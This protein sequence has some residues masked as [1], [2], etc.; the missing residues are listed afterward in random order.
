MA[1][2]PGVDAASLLEHGDWSAVP[3]TLPV[4]ALAF[5]YHNIVPVLVN[6][7]EA[8]V[9][10]VRTA[11]CAGVAIPWIMFVSW[12]AAILGSLGNLQGA[13]AAQAP[14]AELS[15]ATPAGSRDLQQ[16]GAGQQQQVPA[17]TVAADSSIS[18]VSQERVVLDQRSSSS[19]SSQSADP[20]DALAA[21][22]ATVGPLIQGFSFLA[23]ATSYIGFILGLT[24]F[25]S[26]A[27][28]LPNRQAPLPYLLT[29]LPPF[30]VAVTN[31]NIFLQALDTAGMCLVFIHQQS[32]AK[33]CHC[34]V[35]GQ[36]QVVK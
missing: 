36:L 6:A 3:A 35:G 2:G 15:A 32:A 1:A 16:A 5:V 26:D 30:G 34:Q 14:T 20:L 21:G 4:V 8:D 25:M 7:L 33:A 11:I 23:I 10:K 19:G 27:L 12:E 31:P 13:P 28:R 24:D 29:L 9:G 17:P 22:N 18:S